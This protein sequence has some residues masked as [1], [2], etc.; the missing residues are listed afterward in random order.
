MSTELGQNLMR[1]LDQGSA[2]IRG[3]MTQIIDDFIKSFPQ[4]IRGGQITQY[5]VESIL[6][7]FRNDI[8]KAE[9]ELLQR[10]TNVA[11]R[12]IFQLFQQFT[13][14]SET[15]IVQKKSQI[16][17]LQTSLQSTRNELSEANNRVAS[18]A[19]LI[20]EANVSIQSL[21]DER[22]SLYTSVSETTRKFNEIQKE[23]EETKAKAKNF[24]S[25]LSSIEKEA[26]GALDSLAA[27]LSDQEKK[28][29]DRL[30]REKKVWELKYVEKSI[31][32][33]GQKEI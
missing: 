1:I 12:Q 21:M 26:S 13:G 6:R 10:Y 25:Q 8:L 32:D 11:S 28:W 4:M 33:S 29:Q 15:E 30:D 20:E 16:S 14:S 7:K 19:N 22:D 23:L 5:T 2:D 31:S 24:E 3:K 9:Q 27:K 17:E 18:L